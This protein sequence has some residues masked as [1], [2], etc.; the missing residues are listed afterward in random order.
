MKFLS[1]F[2]LTAALSLGQQSPQADQ[3]DLRSRVAE[4]GNS[5]PEFMRALEAHLKKFPGS[6]QK[7][8]VERTL[9]RGAIE[10]KDNVRLV[11]FGSRVLAIDPDDMQA[12]EFTTRALLATDN[13][14]AAA[15]ALTHAKRFEK[16]LRNLE[17]KQGGEPLRWQQR[18]ELD[19]GIGRALVFQARAVGNMGQTDEALKLCQ[20]SFTVNASAE[21]AR[22][23]GRWLA[24]LNKFIEAT[25]SFALGYA[26][27]ANDSERERDLKLVRETWRK[28]HPS[29]AGAGD[30]LIIALDRAVEIKA[31]KKAKFQAIDPNALET[32][33]MRYVLPGVSGLKVS[34]ASL[35]GKVVIMDF[36]AT[37]CGPCRTQHPLYEQVKKR[38]N[39]RDDV[40]FLAIATDEDPS[41]V[42]PFLNSQKWSKQVYFESGLSRLLN[43]TSIP[44]T[45]IFNKNGDVASRMN[46]FAPESFVNVLRDRIQQILDEKTAE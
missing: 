12:L 3:D 41:L 9:F 32:E 31:A 44:T 6:S 24:K 40:I 8:E 33:A 4:A 15:T 27:A 45:I 22:E 42:E 7:A 11:K 29:E 46:G 28:A 30:K 26:L 17:P 36:W 1:A 35:K 13:K 37:W 18:A 43:V 21:A 39:G 5:T 19:Q 20:A 23:Q 14:D 10:L 16:V 2:L 38:F 25:E 34:L